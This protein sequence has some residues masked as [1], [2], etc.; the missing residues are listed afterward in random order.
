MARKTTTLTLVDALASLID[1]LP[2]GLTVSGI[3]SHESGATLALSARNAE[4]VRGLFP[5]ASRSPGYDTGVFTVEGR[6]EVNDGVRRL[7]VEVSARES[8]PTVK[9]LIYAHEDA[10]L[11]SVGAWDAQTGR[12]LYSLSA[13]EERIVL[14]PSD[15]LDTLHRLVGVGVPADTAEAQA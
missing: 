12:R 4:Q 10:D 3:H 5:K 13:G 8:V 14:V 7:A 11:Y 1:S 9:V 2:E 6:A 15:A